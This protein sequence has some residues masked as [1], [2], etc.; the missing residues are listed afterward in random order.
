MKVALEGEKSEAEPAHRVPMS[1][2]A[3]KM[4]SR[5]FFIETSPWSIRPKRQNLV[6]NEEESLSGSAEGKASGIGADPSPIT[7]T[8]VALTEVAPPTALSAPAS[9]K[10]AR[11]AIMVF[12]IFTTSE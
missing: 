7:M 9:I 4:T 6:V 5:R 8:V 11:V 1:I 3:T 2:N 12:F 10:A